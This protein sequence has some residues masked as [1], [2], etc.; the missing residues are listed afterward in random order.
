MVDH[1]LPPIAFTLADTQELVRQAKRLE[2]EVFFES[3]F[4]ADC[5]GD[6]I[7]EYAPFSPYSDFFIA[8]IEGR[9][10]GVVRRI[11]SSLAGLP[12]LNEFDLARRWRLL[13]TR[14]LQRERVAEFAGAVHGAYRGKS[15]A[16]LNGLTR[17]YIQHCLQQGIRWGFGAID[18]GLANIFS[19]FYT[20][21]MT[22][23]GQK[24]HYLGSISTPVVVDFWKEVR[25]LPQKAPDIAATLFE[26]MDME[27]LAAIL[28]EGEEEDRRRRRRGRGPSNP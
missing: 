21:E 20:F 5:S 11:R 28:K 15:H 25:T 10:V 18:Q 24:K 8:V 13:L 4:V 1:E 22:T 9:V 2:L 6:E 17:I 26:G 27:R 14:E 23:V 16:I 19:T 12:T 7:Q 3:G